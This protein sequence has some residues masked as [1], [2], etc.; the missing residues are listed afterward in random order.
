MRIA[1]LLSKDPEL[2]FYLGH[3]NFHSEN[4]FLEGNRG[5]SFVGWHCV[6]KGPL[7]AEVSSSAFV[8]V[9]GD[10][11]TFNYPD[12][13]KDLAEDESREINEKNVST[14]S[15]SIT[16][17]AIC[18]LMGSRQHPWIVR[19]RESI[20]KI[21]RL[22]FHALYLLIETQSCH[23][24]V[25]VTIKKHRRWDMLGIDGSIAYAFTDEELKRQAYCA[26]TFNAHQDFLDQISHLWL[27][28]DG[29]ATS[30]ASIL[31]AL[32]LGRTPRKEAIP[33]SS[34]HHAITL[35]VRRTDFT[36]QDGTYEDCKGK[37]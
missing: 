14:C 22:S 18:Q 21:Q 20:M 16:Y 37:G 2:A 23:N 5:S 3:P 32:L 17:Q 12:K 10:D 25:M 24:P 29:R 6:W 19:F 31:I 1:P 15:P 34:A 36:Q 9:D 11:L 13:Y 33:I 30:A 26:D 7:F 28:V 35:K 4:I 27:D 8:Q